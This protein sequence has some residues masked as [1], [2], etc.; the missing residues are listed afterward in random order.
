MH[1]WG[2][3]K[4]ELQLWENRLAFYWRFRI[5]GTGTH[6][7]LQL[8]ENIVGSPTIFSPSLMT[9]KFTLTSPP[10][11]ELLNLKRA[12]PRVKCEYRHQSL[13]R[14]QEK[15]LFHIMLHKPALNLGAITRWTH[16]KP[17]GFSNMA[18]PPAPSDTGGALNQRW[19]VAYM[20]SSGLVLEK[21]FHGNWKKK[22]RV[23]L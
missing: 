2:P 21:W 16:S 13:L 19:G 22:P 4:P 8:R 23:T 17:G 11:L 12:A 18:A 5:R 9:L 3:M 1:E 7:L 15:G 6:G 14:D 10:S 20:P